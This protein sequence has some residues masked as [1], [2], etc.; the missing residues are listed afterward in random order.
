MRI[1]AAVRREES[2][3]L[4]GVGKGRRV[5]SRGRGAG[6]DGLEE[7]NRFSGR[8]FLDTN[9]SGHLYLGD[10]PSDFTAGCL[11]QTTEDGRTL[12]YR[13][14]CEAKLVT[15]TGLALSLGSEFVENRPGFRKGGPLLC[16]GDRHPDRPGQLPSVGSGRRTEPME[17]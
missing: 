5:L 10:R 12:Y 2:K 1:E 6:R 3:I 4:R 15:R 13:P 9:L 11:T 7:K 8:F 17:D 14:T 16:L